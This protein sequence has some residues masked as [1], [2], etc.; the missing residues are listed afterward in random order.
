MDK[1]GRIYIPEIEL[2]MYCKLILTRVPRSLNE[3]KIIFATDGDAAKI[4]RYPHAKE[5][6]W[7]STS[8]PTQKLIQG[9]SRTKC[10]GNKVNYKT[11]EENIGIHL[12]FAVV[13]VRWFLR[14]GSRSKSESDKKNI[15]RLDYIKV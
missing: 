3:E 9:V 2:Y 1:W 15:Y 13:F 5:L 6:S 11:L 8:C 7:I 10:K 4:A 14:Y 12:H